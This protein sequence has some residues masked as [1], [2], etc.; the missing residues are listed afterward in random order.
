V[1]EN[2]RKDLE[3]FGNLQELASHKA[4]KDAIQVEIN[5][6]LVRMES[7]KDHENEVKWCKV[8]KGRRRP[9]L[10][11]SQQEM[12]ILNNRFQPLYNLNLDESVG[13]S[14]MM[15]Q[16]TL[17]CKNV[18][19]NS[20]NSKRVK[21]KIRILGDSHARGLAIE[22]KHRLNQEFEIQG[23][24]KPGSTV[25]KLTNSVSSEL[26]ELTKKDACIILGGTNDVG[27]NETNIGI[28]SLHEFI[29]CHQH[30]N[31]IV[32]KVPHRYDLASNSCINEEVK[33]FNRKLDK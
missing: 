16:K 9:V 7:F 4:V 20:D 3:E 14:Q 17:K 10:V 1:I 31:V 6:L 33:I 18:D 5:V 30:T 32:L 26:K 25:E 12:P 27:R 22:L 28:R 21:H 15:E 24:I 23:V 8:T 13:R 19:I 29:S 2:L 11:N